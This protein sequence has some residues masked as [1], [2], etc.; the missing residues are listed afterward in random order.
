MPYHRKHTTKP[1][2]ATPFS[3]RGVTNDNFSRP[4]HLSLLSDRQ[5]HGMTQ[6]GNAAGG[7]LANCQAKMDQRTRIQQM[8][9]ITQYLGA[10][11]RGMMINRTAD[12][13]DHFLYW[14]DKLLV[15]MMV[16]PAR[17]QQLLESHYQRFKAA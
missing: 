15:L 6:L 13:V 12:T 8:H 7:I 5:P 17:H 10:A 4:P 2:T 3:P 1:R 11:K 9:M 14:Y 16:P